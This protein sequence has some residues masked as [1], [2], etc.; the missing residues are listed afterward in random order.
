MLVE[1]NNELIPILYVKELAVT[2]DIYD[3][4]VK[5]EFASI[6]DNDIYKYI[7]NWHK[8]DY[9]KTLILTWMKKNRRV[10]FLFYDGFP[11]LVNIN[12]QGYLSSFKLKFQSCQN[13]TR[14][15]KISLLLTEPVMV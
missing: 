9:K 15:Y 7:N 10:F 5:V 6:C 12:N 11:N 3:S 1:W 8:T 13:I 14:K 2:E 4:S